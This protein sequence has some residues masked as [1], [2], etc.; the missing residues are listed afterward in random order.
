[1][2]K[3]SFS[4][5]FKRPRETVFDALTDLD[6]M[7]RAGKEAGP[8]NVEL[9]SVPG[10]PRT[11]LGSAVRIRSGIPSVGEV[12]CEVTEWDPP[13]RA[14]RTLDNEHFGATISLG[15]DEAPEGTRVNIEVELTPRSV[16]SKMMLP[17]IA[18][19]I[20]AEKA[21]MLDQIKGRIDAA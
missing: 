11:G 20:K 7:A 5:V 9:A 21:R 16:M 10:R 12:L 4:I 18:G 14:A 19:R 2:L 1:M 13:R 6:R 8:L 15:F 3:E 17:L